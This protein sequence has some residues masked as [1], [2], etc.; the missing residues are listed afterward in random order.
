ML[1]QMMLLSCAGQKN[2]ACKSQALQGRC[3]L[4]NSL[5]PYQELKS[6]PPLLW[7]P[8]MDVSLELP[9]LLS[10]LCLVSDGLQNL[11][12]CLR[13]DLILLLRLLGSLLIAE[14]CR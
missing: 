14:S 11:P 13:H 6:L 12:P 3:E 7:A 1:K 9:V 5:T 4:A 10:Q 8:D 2:V